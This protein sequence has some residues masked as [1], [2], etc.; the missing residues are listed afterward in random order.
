MPPSAA[1]DFSCGNSVWALWVPYT[2]SGKRDASPED[3]L[4]GMILMS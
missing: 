3:D 1:S 4:G 2:S